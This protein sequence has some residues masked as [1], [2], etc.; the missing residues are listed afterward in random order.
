[1]LKNSDRT[2]MH[3]SRCPYGGVWLCFLVLALI[4]KKKRIWKWE[5]TKALVWSEKFGLNL[6]S[7]ATFHNEAPSELAT[8]MM[9]GDTSDGD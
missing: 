4:Q 7:H 2:L 3:V 9:S 1:M 5:K 8:L 6:I